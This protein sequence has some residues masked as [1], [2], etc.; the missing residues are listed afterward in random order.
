MSEYF[1]LTLFI[2]SQ[3]VEGST[4]T[5][6]MEHLVPSSLS[7]LEP[8]SSTL[9]V[10]LNEEGGI[11]DDTV[12]CK[13]SPTKYY[14]VTNAGRKDRD[15]AWIN[16]KVAEWNSEREAK[17]SVSFTPMYEQGLVALQ[18]SSLKSLLFYVVTN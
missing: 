7:S 8:F 15:V 5:E 12:I 6:F 14:V 13:H 18:G 17:D 4:A 1:F 9:S 10:I 11:I 16:E 3:S 2:L